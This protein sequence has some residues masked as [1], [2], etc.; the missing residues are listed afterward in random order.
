VAFYVYTHIVALYYIAVHL[1]YYITLYKDKP[2][3][4]IVTALEF[5]PENMYSI[6]AGTHRAMCH[7][8]RQEGHPAKISLVRA[9]E[10]SQF[11]FEHI[12]AFAVGSA[13][14]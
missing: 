10:K 14:R 1:T 11:A 2:Q 8:W 13:R 12:P 3:L 5:H 9:P 6:I 7:W 4:S